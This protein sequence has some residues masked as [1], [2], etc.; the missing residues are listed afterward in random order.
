MGKKS[1][2]VLLAISCLLEIFF[3]QLISGSQPVFFP[4]KQV[5]S[6]QHGSF[7]AFRRAKEDLALEKETVSLIVVGDV[8]L[9]RDVAGRIKKH[10]NVDYP[11]LKTGD[12][13]RTA[14]LVFG[15]LE[16]PVTEGRNISSYEMI[17]RAD[18]GVEKSLK[19]AGFSVLS[20][21]NNHIFNFGHQGL[22][23]TFQYLEQAGIKYAGAGSSA[24]EA[25]RPVYLEKKGIKFAFLAYSD[26]SFASTGVAVMDIESMVEAVKQ[27][28]QQADL[29]IVSIHS[30]D[31]Y[32]EKPNQVQINFA[33]AAIDAGA[34]L[35]IGHHPHV[36]Q[37]VEKYKGKYI[38][39][40]LGNFVFDQMW[41]YETQ[42][43]LVAKI[44]F[45][46]RGVA[47][48]EFMPILIEDFAQPRFL[49]QSLAEKALKKLKI[50]LNER[51]TFV[52]KKEKDSFDQQARKVIYHQ[53]Q[54]AAY[55]K[56]KSV[57]A[58]L[59][60]DSREEKYDLENGELRISQNAKI[61][62][63]SSKDWWIDDFALADSTGDGVININLSVWKAGDFGQS[64]PFWVEENDMSIKNHF[65][66]F[67]FE[68][69]KIRAVWQS[70]NLEAPNC[71]FLFEDINGNGKKELI[72][73]ESDYA[74]KEFCQGKYLAVWQWPEWGFTNEWRSHKGK[75][76][77][78]TIEEINGE[79]YIVV[80]GAFD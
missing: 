25:Y 7:S 15:N 47:K 36:I 39:Y 71:E 57:T 54:K 43:G 2:I 80:D 75:F 45:D 51:M 74:D 78:L 44:F 1:F 61:I 68:D 9:S 70:S 13:L 66:V 59:N 67:K 55:K 79:K 62:W 65:F 28:K 14:D 20:L 29:V 4:K 17:F 18:P 10:Q 26:K 37:E 12:Y 11:F 50:A 76:E 73:I 5:V 27:A 60:N 16:S 40:S 46:E 21:A 64:K 56:A 31:E 52:W 8:M 53:K 72:V 63:K 48:I 23:D 32:A 6:S 58:D 24:E 38:F 42:E 77:N 41:S 69:N 35:V 33:R 30:G 19:A 49:E 3:L 22:E 34:E